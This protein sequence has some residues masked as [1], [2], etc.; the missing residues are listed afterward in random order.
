MNRSIIIAG[1][2]TTVSSA[3]AVLYVLATYPDV[4]AKAQ[5]EIDSVI[6]LDRLPLV[7]DRGELPY[8]HAIV[9]EVSRWYTVVPLGGSHCSRG[10]IDTISQH[11]CQ[12][13]P[14]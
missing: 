2:E 10:D 8:T 4:Q 9:K 1:A 6:G 5:A 13:L 11:W 3:T 14:L 7:K 12:S